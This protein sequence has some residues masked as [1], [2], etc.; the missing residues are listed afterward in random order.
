MPDKLKYGYLNRYRM[1]Q[2]GKIPVTEPLTILNNKSVQAGGQ[3]L[4]MM[5]K[6]KILAKKTT[7]R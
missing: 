4:E 5:G 1:V 3:L 2:G 6:K 7:Y